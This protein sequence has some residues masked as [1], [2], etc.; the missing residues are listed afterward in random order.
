MPYGLII[1]TSRVRTF[2][3][4]GFFLYFGASLFSSG[5]EPFDELVYKMLSIRPRTRSS[6][7][8]HAVDR[9]GISP[10]DVTK[11]LRRL[12]GELVLTPFPGSGSQRPTHVFSLVELSEIEHVACKSEIE[13]ALNLK[14]PQAIR[15][16]S[17]VYGRAIFLKA[18]DEGAYFYEEIPQKRRL[19]QIVLAGTRHRADLTLTY[20]RSRAERI[21]LLVEIKAHRERFDVTSPIFVKLIRASMVTNHQPVLFA[22]YLSDRAKFFCDAVGIAWLEFGRQFLPAARKAEAKLL[23]PKTFADRFQFIRVNRVF[24]DD[25]GLP[26]LSRIDI[27]LI[28]RRSWVRAA[29]VSWA[30]LSKSR[31]PTL[32]EALER[33]DWPTVNRYAPGLDSF[34]R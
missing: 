8:Y 9:L 20:V 29:T 30:A 25:L 2:V 23:Y 15:L 1:F 7:E 10:N 32:C 19:G 28:K 21:R 27:D 24:R 18:R 13:K 3:R 16:A 34:T 33:K 12:K 31:L 22:S 11:Y 14:A 26:S 6:I 17:E 4:H 5:N